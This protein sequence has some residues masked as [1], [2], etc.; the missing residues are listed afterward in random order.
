MSGKINL[1]PPSGFRDFLPEEAAFRQQTF[2][3]VRG[4]FERHGFLP[5][6]TPA[7]ERLEVSRGVYGQEAENK[8]T[9]RALRRGEDLAEA[10][11]RLPA[12][13]DAALSELGLRYDLTLP[14]ARVVASRRGALPPVFRRYQL[15]PVWR[16]DR[17]GR[18]RFREFYQCDLDILGTSS[19]LAEAEVLTAGLS[20]LRGLGFRDAVLKINHRGVMR[21]LL[22]EAGVP[23]ELHKAVLG[24]LDKLDKAGRE[25]VSQEWAELGA[26]SAALWSVL[27]EG[28]LRGLLSRRPEGLKALDEIAALS[29]ALRAEAVC[30]RVEADF[31]LARGL[32]YYT[33][34][35]YEVQVPGY[36][37][38]V[39]GGGRYDGLV[40]ALGGPPTPACGFSLGIERILMLM[41]EDPARRPPFS[42]LS[43]PE[44]MVL[45]PGEAATPRAA[46]WARTLR[47]WGVR[48]S[49]H[50]EPSQSLGQQFRRAA[51]SGA[52]LA[53]LV[54]DR[55]EA[56]GVVA[57][58]DLVAKEQHEVPRA[59]VQDLLRSLLRRDLSP[60]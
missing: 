48:T 49:L 57:I 27:E 19:L 9:F 51:E 36:E 44:A 21:A 56:A 34:L 46:E 13:G 58:K 33:G 28:D 45:V 54:G 4:V 22:A 3:W 50:L 15:A 52:R 2:A 26:S 6:E 7:L 29:E 14:L 43:G 23:L 35:I 12:E 41:Q 5:L 39:G 40:E 24:A 32:D 53:L 30:S 16:A 18:G 42:P 17:P 8:L 47:S 31:T 55:E 38:S 10:L 1:A 11:T 37:G 25:A 20:A 59:G 60:L